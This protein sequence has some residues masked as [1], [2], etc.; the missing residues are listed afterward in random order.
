MW[1]GQAEALFDVAKRPWLVGI[2]QAYKQWTY[3]Q[4]GAGLD[5]HDDVDKAPDDWNKVFFCL[6]ARA[7]APSTQTEIEANLLSPLISLPNK[8]FFDVTTEFL[9]HLD[10]VYFN[11]ETLSEAAAVYIRSSLAQRIVATYSWKRLC[12]KSNRG[13]EAGF[14]PALAVIFFNDFHPYT[15]QPP[16]CYLPPALIDKIAPFLRTL[17]ILIR[18]GSSVFSALLTLSLLEVSPSP[19]LLPLAMAGAQAWLDHRTDT[20][21]WV[22]EGI[23]RRL[24]EWLEKLFNIDPRQFAPSS[25]IRRDVD[26]SLATLITFGVPEATRLE[27]SIAMR[28]A[29]H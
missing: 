13:V 16:K 9:R 6:A 3:R 7:I 29:S 12:D 24:V 4:N 1:L 23:G 15:H 25:S 21:F 27:T 10:I 11:F 20:D 14:G 5:E 22:G 2:F 18:N 28:D 26:R 17:E 19:A 8:Q